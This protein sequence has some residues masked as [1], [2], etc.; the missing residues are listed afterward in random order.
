MENKTQ[1]IRL[2]KPS[3]GVE[4][5]EAIQSVIDE[6]SLRLGLDSRKLKGE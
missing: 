3:V 5:L 4:E 2:F 1:H 6:A